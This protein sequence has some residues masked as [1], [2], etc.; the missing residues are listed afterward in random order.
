MWHIH[1][2]EYYSTIERNGGFSFTARMNLKG[3]ML[4]EI[5]QI[6]KDKYCM[7]S[8]HFY[9]EFKKQNMNKRNKTETDF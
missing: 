3:I 6:E 9:V 7:T 8:F 4:S 2:M 1:T 5:S